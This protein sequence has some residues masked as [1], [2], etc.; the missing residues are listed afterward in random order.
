MSCESNKYFK[1]GM[2]FVARCTI[3]SVPGGITSLDGYIVTSAVKTSDD[4]RHTADSVTV[5]GMVVTVRINDTRTWPIGEA[6]Q[7][8]LCTP[9]NG[10]PGIYT[11]TWVFMVEENITPPND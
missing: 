2:G 6:R 11:R 9:A 7:D 3:P 4:V 1:P 5:N 10:D 8:L